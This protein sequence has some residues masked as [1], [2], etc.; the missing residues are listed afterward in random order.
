MHGTQRRGLPGCHRS[1]QRQMIFYSTFFSVLK[2]FGPTLGQNSKLMRD[3][4][5]EVVCKF[6]VDCLDNDPSIMNPSNR[7]PLFASLQLR[8]SFRRE[9]KLRFCLQNVPRLS[10]HFPNLRDLDNRSVCWTKNSYLLETMKW[11]QNNGTKVS[12][13][14]VM[15][16]WR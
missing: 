14:H 7:P 5:T 2:Y 6:F 16:S 11:E 13:S 9:A 3:F 10:Q 12:R 4:H 1:G 15:V 8:S